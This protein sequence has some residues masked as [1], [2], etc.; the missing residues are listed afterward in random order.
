M[1][2]WIMYNWGKMS[3]FDLYRFYRFLL[4]SKG[5]CNFDNDSYG[6]TGSIITCVF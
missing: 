4:R 5:V 1:L 2:Q 6:Y 3:N